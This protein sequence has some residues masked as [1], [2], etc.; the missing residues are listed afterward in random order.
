MHPQYERH[1]LHKREALL[2]RKYSV[3]WRGIMRAKFTEPGAGTA[4]KAP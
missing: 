2:M 3:C 4:F 1:F